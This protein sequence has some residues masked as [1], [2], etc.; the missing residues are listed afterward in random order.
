M[1]LRDIEKKAANSHQQNV[2]TATMWDRCLSSK[3]WIV[4]SLCLSFSL[5]LV[6]AHDAISTTCGN[7]GLCNL[8]CSASLHEPCSP[9]FPLNSSLRRCVW[10]RSLRCAD[11]CTFPIARLRVSEGL[12]PVVSLW[13]SIHTEGVVTGYPWLNTFA[14]RSFTMT[15]TPRSLSHVSPQIAFIW[16]QKK[17][18]EMLSCGNIDLNLLH[19]GKLRHGLHPVN[20]HVTAMQHLDTRHR[21]FKLTNKRVLRAPSVDEWSVPSVENESGRERTS[22][23][24]IPFSTVGAH[25]GRRAAQTLVA[26][27]PAVHTAVQINLSMSHVTGALARSCLCLGQS[28]DSRQACLEYPL[29]GAEW[30]SC[31][32]L[33]CP[34]CPSCTACCRHKKRSSTCRV[35]PSVCRA[36]MSF[37]ALKSGRSVK[38]PLSCGR[39]SSQGCS[40]RWKT[41]SG[42]G[43]ERVPVPECHPVRQSVRLCAMTCKCFWAKRMTLCFVTCSHA[44]AWGQ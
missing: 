15:R 42:K 36:D 44:G 13:H 38:P 14:P 29:T 12:H 6:F 37:F 11:C 34:K 21:K 3:T 23:E 18:T 19:A 2:I 41:D 35:F 10:S 9:K 17:N 5:T 25:A 31:P 22:T 20:L 4:F 32:V 24:T 40:A 33:S 26:T 30:M 28:A 7:E 43:E 8:F 27:K 1:W 39:R 16:T